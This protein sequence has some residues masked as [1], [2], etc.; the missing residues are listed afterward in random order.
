MLI[1]D[2]LE[3]IIRKFEGVEA[4]DLSIIQD[5]ISRSWEYEKSWSGS[6]LGYHSN[7]Y[8]KDFKNPPPGTYFNPEWG[9]NNISYLSSMGLNSIGDWVEY[10]RK[11][12]RENILRHV[13]EH[14]INI[15]INFSNK[16]RS[17]LEDSKD[18]VLSIIYSQNI[19]SQDD[20]LSKLVDFFK[21]FIVFRQ[22]D[23]EK[24]F[25]KKFSGEFL[26]SDPRLQSG[27]ISARLPEHQIIICTMMD[28]LSPFSQ[29]KDFIKYL[30]KI[31]EHIRNIQT[32]MVNKEMI[33]NFNKSNGKEKTIY[34]IGSVQNMANHNS[35][36]HLQQSVNNQSLSIFDEI[37]NKVQESN[38][39]Q[40]LIKELMALIEEMDKNKNTSEYKTSYG[41]FIENTTKS[42]G[43]LHSIIDFIPKLGNYLP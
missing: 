8:Y 1:I 20:Y 18:N 2:K 25:L 6:I 32:V 23:F 37:K 21:N 15:I 19:I 29:T 5:I 31:Q 33:N 22:K 35:G 26:T 7:I 10:D 3:E 13:D 40:E 14:S 24:N 9:V 12:I 43:L 36:D 39:D 42:V 27:N 11:Y 4:E 34:N 30:K 28:I 16:I 38:E 41:K 17:L